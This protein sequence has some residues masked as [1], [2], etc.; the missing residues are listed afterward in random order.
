MRTALKVLSAMIIAAIVS[1]CSVDRILS[2]KKAI[3]TFALNEDK[4][5]IVIN[6]HKGEIVH[7]CEDRASGKGDLQPCKYP[8]GFGDTSDDMGHRKTMNQ[9]NDTAKSHSKTVAFKAHEIFITNFPG[10]F[11]QSIYN[12]ATGMRYEICWPE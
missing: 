9:S 3:A 7:S 1:G 11:C 4:E 6:V 8:K 2:D 10:S 5:F 12:K